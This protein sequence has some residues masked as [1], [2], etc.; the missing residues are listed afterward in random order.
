MRILVS[1]FS[2]APHQGSEPGV[3]WRWAQELA[4]EHDVV[5]LTDATR[6]DAAEAELQ[7]HPQPRLR[8]VY[9]RPAWLR[10]VPLN[11]TTAQVLYALWQFS[12]PRL[13]R[14]L[15]A[16]APF[17]LVLH[18][19][20]GVF[21]H[22]SFLGG[23]G[24]P[25]IF[26][27]LGGGEDA[28]RALKRSIHGRERVKEALRSA[29]NRLALFDPT[30]WWACAR[31]D[32]ILAKTAETRDALPWPF[33]RRTQVFAEIGID[34]PA[35]VAPPARAAGEPLQLLFAGR[36]L[37]WK[38]AHLALRAVAL[39]RQR[40]HDVRLDIV[41]IGPYEPALR[42]LHE[43]LQ[44]GDAVRFV[45]RLPQAELFALYRRV[46]GL[47]FPSLHDSSGNVVLEAQAQGC[48]VIC[49]DLGGPAT[50]VVAESAVVV[51][52][53]GADEVRVVERLADAIVRLA[54]D[55]PQRQAMAQAAWR[56]ARGHSWAGRVR[57]CLQLAAEHGLV[58]AR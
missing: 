44:V 5:V 35:D 30:L 15:Q 6:R 32:L 40:G 1:A 13:A 20:Y 46:H 9:H 36:L 38:G 49:L 24:V 2:F 42:R 22:A 56:H 31:A 54:G 28:P 57:A 55:E 37:G 43:G 16:E 39:A 23:L 27:P 14:R 34:A 58:G 52:T 51:S 29:V 7:A 8:V 10:R 3:G 45:G 21:R 17:D 50:L 48:P 25:F 19:T 18:L 47:L 53:R 33:R 12:L 11:S 26:G 41:G 4:H